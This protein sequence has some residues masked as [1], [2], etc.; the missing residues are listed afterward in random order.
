MPGGLLLKDLLYA[1][2][3]ALLAESPEELAAV[4]SVCEE[5]ETAVGLQFSV[6]KS[7]L[8]LLVGNQVTANLPTIRLYGE[9]LEWV[10]CFTYL[11]FPIYARGHSPGYLPLDLSLV[12]SVMYPT[13][14][15]VHPRPIHSQLTSVPPSSSPCNNGRRERGAQ[16]SNGR[17]G[18]PQN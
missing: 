1:D 6:K 4:L 18:L 8:L 14:S 17:Y 11:G 9:A 12:N 2:D 13:A 7:K 16:R 5:W 15:V 10:D 3:V